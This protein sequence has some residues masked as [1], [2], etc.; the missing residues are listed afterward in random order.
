MWV[1]GVMLVVESQ[2]RGGPAA[3]PP[4]PPFSLLARPQPIARIHTSHRHV[5][6]L[7]LTRYNVHT[8]TT[9]VLY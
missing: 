2:L 5:N 6:S 8:P 3:G 4:S 1:E 7:P 9:E